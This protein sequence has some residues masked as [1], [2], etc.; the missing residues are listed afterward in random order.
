MNKTEKDQGGRGKKAKRKI[1]VIG[2]KC[3]RKGDSQEKDTEGK[4]L[5]DIKQ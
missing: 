5:R 2:K 3:E 4:R 1:Q